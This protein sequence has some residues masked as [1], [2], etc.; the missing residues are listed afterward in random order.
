MAD[1][2]NSVRWTVLAAAALVSLAGPSRA[3]PPE[4]MP[5]AT[6]S[7]EATANP[8]PSATAAPDL[9]PTP[10]ATPDFLFTPD[11][12]DL[13][14]KIDAP[15]IPKDP[16][17]G[18]PIPIDPGDGGAAP[19]VNLSDIGLSGWVTARYDAHDGLS[20][21][22]TSRNGY[23]LQNVRLKASGQVHPRLAFAASVDAATGDAELRDGYATLTLFPFLDLTVGQFNKPYGVEVPRSETVLVPVDRSL[24]GRV[25]GRY[26]DEVRDRGLMLHGSL[27]R[28]PTL[29]YAVAVVN[30][31]GEAA[32]TNP[33]KDVVAR[34]GPSLAGKGWSVRLGANVAAGKG[35]EDLVVAGTEQ[36]YW[37]TGYDL[38]VV[39]GPVLLVTEGTLG[40]ATILN[41]PEGVGRRTM[42]QSG[43]YGLLAVTAGAFTPWVRYDY[44]ELTS[45]YGCENPLGLPDWTAAATVGLNLSLL[46]GHLLWRNAYQWTAGYV[47]GTETL[48]ADTPAGVASTSLQLLF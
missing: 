10:E 33:D 26:K 36:E 22:E 25:G 19:R 14:I 20:E 31:E 24:A 18:L 21:N 9:S 42:S 34:V 43:A 11:P 3:A 12:K 30:G 44:R 23:A 8:S 37:F 28:A 17:T 2:R 35:I 5:F 1:L 40:G 38:Q 7:P 13:K 29:E 6:P 46:D 32:E 48:R 27:F 39:A 4:A 47:E 15:D 45:I 16:I 41:P